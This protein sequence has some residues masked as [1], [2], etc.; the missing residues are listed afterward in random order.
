MDAI[1][2]VLAISSKYLRSQNL[3]E[4]IYSNENDEY[5]VNTCSV[6][7]FYR[8][9]ESDHLLN[10]NNEAGVEIEF[11]RRVNANGTSQYKVNGK[12]I[13]CDNYIKKLAEFNILVNCR[14]FLVYQ[15]DVQNISTRSPEELTLLFEQISGSYDLRNEYEQLKENRDRL[16]AVMDL[17]MKKKYTMISEKKVVEEQKEEADE[18]QRKYEL[19]RDLRVEYFLWQL[20]NIESNLEEHAKKSE[21]LKQKEEEVEESDLVGSRF[22][23]STKYLNELFL[24]M[25]FENDF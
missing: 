25:I 4:L 7:L 10:E 5:A 6:S 16:K 17:N 23:Y 20:R 13:T 2:F 9:D 19:L 11:F 14:N 12:Q 15:G 21:L 3:Q 22:S 1:S 8:T 24:R 18:F